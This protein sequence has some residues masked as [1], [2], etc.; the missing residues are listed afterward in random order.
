MKKATF[1]LSLFAAPA[2]FGQGG[3][4]PND[5]LKP[6]T[7]QW[8]SYSG[9]YTAK[10]FSHL[11]QINTETVK[12]LSLKWI[13]TGIQTG[14]GP[15][16]TPPAGGAQAGGF[17]RGGPV[18]PP[19]P[20]IVGG[21]GTGELN[22]CGPARLG[23]GILVVNGTI[24][25]SAPD[26]V[27]AIDAHDGSVLWH[28]YWK[29]RGGTSL[30]TRGLGMWHNYIYFELHD[31]WVVCIDAKNGKEVWKKEISS[32]D[33]QYFSS[34]APMVFGNHVIVGTGN[35]MDAPG[36]IKSLDPET[37]ELQWIHYSTPQNPGDPGVE[38]WAS[39]D[40]ARHGGGMTWIP[41]AY[42][43][44]TH[45]YIYGTGNP[46]P[47]YT[48]GR[49]EGDNLFTCALLAVNV[50]TGKMAWY[51]QTSPHDTHD[52]DSTETP[53]LADMPFNGK[54]RKLVLTATRNGYFFV[55]DRTTGEHLLTSKYGLV[56]N[57]ASGYDAKG[58][59]KRN[60][61]KDA[62]IAG[63][64]VNADVSNYPPPSFSPDTGLFYVHE[65]NS[66]HISYLMDPDPR[67]SM[68]L[69][70]TGSGANMSFGTN[71]VAIDYKTGKVA[72]RHELT[73]GSVGLL[74]TAGGVLF[75]SDGQNL[76]AWDA[77]TGK[78]LWH[79]QI[80]G[81]SSP[82]ETFLLDGKQQVLAASPAGLMLFQLN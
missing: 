40:A 45:L 2:M 61:N 36:Y 56:N 73:G 66:M 81:V 65:T 67:G 7:D 13:S 48:T 34:N 18:G 82:P 74:T 24:Y 4:D 49:G 29:T 46:T 22:T 63:S 8:T 75:T 47:A 26:N 39:L 10:R 72:W 41:G 21:F 68:G 78:P 9:D 77:K 59:P 69:G 53:I 71:I 76:A 79:S 28:Y 6:L 27:W 14:C 32:F 33:Q 42:D 37:G 43:P 1:L 64:L 5:L 60:P 54:M 12:N 11:K 17:G 16:G 52:W 50:D 62:T 31:D 58:Q 25:A 55:L 35:D 20:I 30:Q 70:G 44:E 19:A 3:L 38:T 15:T 57:W 80:G 23:G 51:Y